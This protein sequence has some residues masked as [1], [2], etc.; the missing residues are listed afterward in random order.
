M[1]N[2]HEHVKRVKML[3]LF[4]YQLDF[5]IFVLSLSEPVLPHEPASMD[6]SRDSGK[7]SHPLTE[8]DKRFLQLYGK[9][10]TGHL[11]HHQLEVLLSI[12]SKVPVRMPLNQFLVQGR[13]YFDSGDFALSQAHQP[14][15]IGAVKTGSTQPLREGISRPSCPVPNSSN[16]ESDANQQLQGGKHASVAKSLSHLHQGEV[17]QIGELQEK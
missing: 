5:G 17:C 11:S 16:V 13:K 2:N 3:Y 12:V 9:I 1:E 4:L 10:P 7:D 8:R 14:S 6:S 15:D